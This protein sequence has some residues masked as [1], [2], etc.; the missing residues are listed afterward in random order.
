MK[1]SEKEKI[2]SELFLYQNKSE[3]LVKILIWIVSWISG[4]AV[5]IK[6]DDK[7]AIAGA[8]LLFSLSLLMEFGPE[9]KKKTHIISRIVHCF[10][11]FSLMIILLGSFASIMGDR[12]LGERVLG[13]F[14]V[15]M[16]SISIAIVISMLADYVL[17]WI[18]PV[19]SPI[20]T[21]D[22]TTAEASD[23]L[24]IFTENLNKNNQY[25]RGEIDDE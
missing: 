21:S 17:I 16:F 14:N 4:I 6:S 22:N 8:F 25:N 20:E 18:S 19:L 13:I 3:A 9:I 5:I 1:S 2:I 11:C 24:K 15:I 23:K 7:R 10:F 12:L